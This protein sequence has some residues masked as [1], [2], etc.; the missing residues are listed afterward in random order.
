MV[1]DSIMADLDFAVD[2]IFEDMGNRT[3]FNK[4]YALAMQARICLHEGT[5]R[6]YHDEL[7][8][9]N[10]ANVYLEKAIAASQ[11]IMESDLFKIDKVGGQ[12]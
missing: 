7:N 9:Q 2:N 3:Q 6:K 4:W 11:K 5:F 10:T 12:G 1:V 8:L